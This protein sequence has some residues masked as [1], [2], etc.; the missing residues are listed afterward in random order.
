M[1]RERKKGRKAHQSRSG[2]FPDQPPLTGGGRLVGD[3]RVKGLPYGT[4]KG[5]IVHLASALGVE[6]AQQVQELLVPHTD[7][8]A[9]QPAPELAVRHGAVAGLRK[10]KKRRDAEISVS[11]GRVRACWGRR[12]KKKKKKNNNN[13]KW[14]EKTGHRKINRLGQRC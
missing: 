1:E 7:P 9:L 10:Q 5:A 11:S 3:G 8:R 4:R 6:R 14:R 2:I 12:E 13:N